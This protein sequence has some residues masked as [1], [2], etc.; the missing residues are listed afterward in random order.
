MIGYAAWRKYV[1]CRS[2][3]TLH[4]RFLA[5][6]NPQLTG[7]CEVCVS[8]GP[9]SFIQVR[10]VP[11]VIGLAI[12]GIYPYCLSKIRYGGIVGAFVNIRTASIEIGPDI[13][14]IE[15]YCLGGI[16]Y[17]GI[18]VIFDKIQKSPV[19]IGVGIIWIEPYCLGVIRY[20]TVVVAFG[21]V[22]RTSVFK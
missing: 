21:Y 8:S 9:V 19:L 14:G 6:S 22:R 10:N 15:P 2:S 17:G 3:G 5:P 20:G 7:F 13:I 11:E 12:I 4:G 1:A 16:Y 18:I